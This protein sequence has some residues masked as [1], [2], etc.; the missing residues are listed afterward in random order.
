MHE[1]D[2]TDLERL[3]RRKRLALVLRFYSDQL[4]EQG[5]FMGANLI[6]HAAKELED[7]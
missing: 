7:A 3:S 4:N 2:G 6:R 1:A 5:A